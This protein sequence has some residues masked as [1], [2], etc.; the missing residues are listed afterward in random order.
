MLHSFYLMEAGKDN[1]FCIAEQM[2]TTYFII[3]N[4]FTT[5]KK[6]SNPG[7]FTAFLA[8][9]SVCYYMEKGTVVTESHK[10]IK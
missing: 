3:R 9:F 5:E 1:E 10:A 4:R 2:Y 8:F 6:F 7:K